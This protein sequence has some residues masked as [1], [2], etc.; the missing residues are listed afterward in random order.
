MRALRF[1]KGTVRFDAASTAP[2]PGPGEALIRPTRVCIGSADLAVAAGRVAF[3][4]VMGHRFVGVV[5]KLHE[6]ATAEESKAWIGKRVV[7]SISIVCGKCERCRQGLSAHCQLRTVLGLA[8]R[9]GCFADRFTLPMVNLHEVPKS[10]PDDSAVFAE[11]L[12]GVLH[13]GHMLRIEGK[14]YVTVLGDGL[15]GLLAAQVL[16]KL[17]ASVRLLGTNPDKLALCE[18]WGI[19][20]RHIDEVGRRQ[21]QDVIVDCS[22]SPRGLELAMQLVRPRGKIVLR[23]TPA[24]IPAPALSPERGVDLAP[25]V[26]NELELIGARCGRINDALELLAKNAVETAS[27]ITTRTKLDRAVEALR[28]AAMPEQVAVVMEV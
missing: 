7:G 12:A 23:T 25:A 17:N 2:V 8:G 27:L 3:N 10:V 24:P 20:H 5:E 15:T 4:G 21:D 11:P 22:G 26:V 18:K 19:K 6:R 16:V 13:A 9:D 28:H 1:E 14:P